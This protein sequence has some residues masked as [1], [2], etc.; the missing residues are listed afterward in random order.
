V[1]TELKSFA[2]DAVGFIQIRLSSLAG[3]SVRRI[4][5]FRSVYFH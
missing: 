2:R 3:E 1:F 5:E 4:P